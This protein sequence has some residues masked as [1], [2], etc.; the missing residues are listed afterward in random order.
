M[1]CSFYIRKD[2]S[3]RPF[4]LLKELDDALAYC[5]AERILI[6]NDFEPVLLTV[7]GRQ[8]STPETAKPLSTASANRFRIVPHTS[9]IDDYNQIL[10]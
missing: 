5:L 1:G 4:Y 6:G 2:C 7:A 9:N 10:Q 3:N 8:V